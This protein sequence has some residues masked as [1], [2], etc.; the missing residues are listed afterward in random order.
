MIKNVIDRARVQS[1]ARDDFDYVVLVGNDALFPFFRYPDPSPLSK[2]SDYAPP[3]AP[4]SASRASM[5]LGYLLT[6]DTYGA[7]TEI[8]QSDGLLPIPDL[9]VGRLV[10]TADDVNALLDAYVGLT[11]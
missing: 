2:E 8:M 4:D 9:P 6:Q 3:S 1:R 11:Q 10:E 5:A 7:S